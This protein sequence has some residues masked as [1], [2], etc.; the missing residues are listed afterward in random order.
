MSSWDERHASAAS[1]TDTLP[2][3]QCGVLPTKLL[4]PEQLAVVLDCSGH[5]LV[6]AGAGT[7]KTTLLVAK[8]FYMNWVFVRSLAM[9]RRPHW[10]STELWLSHSRGK[11]PPRS[12]TDCVDSSFSVPARLKAVTASD[13]PGRRFCSIMWLWGPS[14]RL[15]AVSCGTMVPSSASKLNSRSWRAARRRS[16]RPKW[17]PQKF[18]AVSGRATRGRSSSYGIMGTCDIWELL[19][20]LIGQAALLRDIAERPEARPVAWRELVKVTATDLLLEPYAR[21]VLHLVTKAERQYVARL[22]MRGRSTIITWCWRR[23]GSRTS[24]RCRMRSSR[25]CG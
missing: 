12:V 19:A 9:A 25:G 23:P 24:P 17:P 20:E 22:K 10:T 4:T 11:Q 14:T 2:D 13:G 1:L 21:D 16:C 6:E 15:R 7:G 8:I 3:A 18:S 5:Q